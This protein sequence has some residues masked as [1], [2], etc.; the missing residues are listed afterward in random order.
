M[1]LRK[2]ELWGKEDLGKFVVITVLME[3]QICT[4]SMICVA[5]SSVKVVWVQTLPAADRFVSVQ[6]INL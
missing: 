1:G 3:S 5:V 2:N 6:H 4:K